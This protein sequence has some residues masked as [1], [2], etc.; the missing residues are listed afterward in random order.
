V[1]Q[2]FGHEGH[3]SSAIIAE[4]A[5]RAMMIDGARLNPMDKRLPPVTGAMLK[6]YLA[7]PLALFEYRVGFINPVFLKVRDG[8]HRN[9]FLC[10]HHGLE[11][12]DVYPAI[13]IAQSDDRPCQRRLC[14]I[15]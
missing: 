7:G 3:A 10:Q 8:R 15:R 11:R 1:L 4:D 14:T 12:D 6:P 13:T 9:R 5:Y 2:S